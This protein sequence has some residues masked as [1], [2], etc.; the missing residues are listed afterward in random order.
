MKLILFVLV[1]TLVKNS[2]QSS[3]SYTG[4]HP[5]SSCAACIEWCNPPHTHIACGCTDFTCDPVP[6]DLLPFNFSYTSK[7]CTDLANSQVCQCQTEFAPQLYSYGSG[8]NNATACT[9][10]PELCPGPNTTCAL[11]TDAPTL[12]PTTSTPTL[13]PTT[14]A[15]TTS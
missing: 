14:S 13:D 10:T 2:V 5:L 8:C 3:C 7:V 11:T 12:T 4:P 6:E 15:P 9:D 1:L